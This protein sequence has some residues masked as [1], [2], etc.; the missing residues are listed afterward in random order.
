MTA[1]VVPEQCPCSVSAPG[2]KNDCGA[3]RVDPKLWETSVCAFF[4]LPV[5]GEGT[6]DRIRF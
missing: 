1:C 3:A 2:H 5:L 4:T 6:I